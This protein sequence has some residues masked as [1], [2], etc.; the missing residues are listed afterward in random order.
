MAGTRVMFVSGGEP[1]EGC[2]AITLL[3]VGDSPDEVESRA[4]DLG[5][6]HPSAWGDMRIR[7]RD[8]DLA[9]ADKRGFGWKPGRERDW[10]GSDSWPGHGSLADTT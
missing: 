6:W 9:L 7:P 2:D 10:Q 3:V 8:V 5:V 1:I 4:R